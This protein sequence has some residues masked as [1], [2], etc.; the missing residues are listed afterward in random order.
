MGGEVYVDV[1]CNGSLGNS[2]NGVNRSQF[3]YYNGT[4]CEVNFH[5]TEFHRKYQ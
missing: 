1:V 5:V 2:S 3:P 4:F